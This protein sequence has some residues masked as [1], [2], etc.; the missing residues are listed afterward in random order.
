MYGSENVKKVTHLLLVYVF[1]TNLKIS[2][3]PCGKL[4]NKV[5]ILTKLNTSCIL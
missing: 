4:Y 2:V 1:I 3:S 5:S